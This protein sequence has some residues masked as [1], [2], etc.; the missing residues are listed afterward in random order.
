MTGTGPLSWSA[1]LRAV[2][3]VASAVVAV[4]LGAAVLTSFLP[5]DLQRLVFHTPLA[6]LV[7]VVVTAWILWGIARRR[8]TDGGD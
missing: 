1:S 4:V 2:L 5:V 3:L 8:P 6:I 7:L